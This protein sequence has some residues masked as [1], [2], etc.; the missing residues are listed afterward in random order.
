MITILLEPH[1]MVV[2]V[3][4]KVVV[5]QDVKQVV[6]VVLQD[7]LDVPLVMVDAKYAQYVNQDV[8][9]LHVKDVILL[10]MDQQ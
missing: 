3:S 7:V 4:A 5:R 2:Q 9:M 8:I 6:P 1:V 10:V